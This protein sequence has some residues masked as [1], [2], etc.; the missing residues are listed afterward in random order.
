MQEFE[1]NDELGENHVLF[2]C[3]S[4]GASAS[5]SANVRMRVDSIVY[6]REKK[7]GLEE[8]GEER[9][10][11]MYFVHGLCTYGFYVGDWRRA[12]RFSC[13]V[14][15]GRGLGWLLGFLLGF[16]VCLLAWLAYCSWYTQIATLALCFLHSYASSLESQFS[17][18]W[19]SQHPST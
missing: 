16:S 4:T 12:I 17:N 11:I 18:C 14:L 9:G 13:L 15:F 8:R 10:C 5:A 3:A 2:L 6:E 1:R 19:S 7:E